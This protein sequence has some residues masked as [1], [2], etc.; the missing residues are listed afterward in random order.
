MPAPLGW[1]RREAA[2]SEHSHTSSGARMV[3]SGPQ[4]PA[5]LGI[6]GWVTGII[7]RSG[8]IEL[9]GGRAAHEHYLGL[10]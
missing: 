3:R 9:A 2:G 10:G 5:W 8:P 7:A 1:T 6:V 4:E